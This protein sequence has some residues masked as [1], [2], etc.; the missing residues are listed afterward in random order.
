[1][2]KI[3]FA[4]SLFLVISAQAQIKFEKGYFISNNGNRTECYI[5]NLD[6][7]NNPNSFEYKT[8]MKSDSVHEESIYGNREFGIVNV[9]KYVRY[10]VNIERSET[11]INNLSK[12]K[13]AQ[14]KEETLF[15]KTLISGSASLYLYTADNITK[16][17]YETATT[18]IEQLI[19]I[20][21]INNNFSTN[22]ANSFSENI[23]ENNQFRQQLLNNV[24]CSEPPESDFSTVSY[25]KNEL[26]KL[27]EKYNA[28]NKSA[29]EEAVNYNDKVKRKSFALK[30]APG[31]YMASL[32]VSD[33]HQYY[34]VST[35]FKK[36]VF[37]IA[38]EAEYILPF[39]NNTWSIFVNPSYHK[40][41]DTKNYNRNDGFGVIS[42]DNNYT[43]NVKYSAIELPFGVRRYFFLN[44]SSKI[45]INAMYVYNLSISDSKISFTNNTFGTAG[46]NRF[47]IAP[48]NNFGLGAGYSYKKFSV[49]FRVNT[50]RNITDLI[51]WNIDYNT[52]GI[53]LGYNVF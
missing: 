11:N 49:E 34:N 8:D 4:I 44:A 53:I 31:L 9:S 23:S 2:K 22:G 13:A 39:S 36:T 42:K 16:Y 14:F 25:R 38:V 32:S 47:D 26:I 52:N 41:S 21:Y 19:Y 15:L 43:A 50:T 30:F 6:W 28:C 37:K 45:F 17:F 48:R 20:K 29:S 5:K 7:R 12:T 33:P 27:F 3:L 46:N 24:R 40:F 51:E 10:K 1:M 35:E 18:P